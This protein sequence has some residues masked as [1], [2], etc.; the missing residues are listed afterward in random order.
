MPPEGRPRK[1][2]PVGSERMTET[3]TRAP[4]SRKEDWITL[5][6]RRVYDDAIQEAVPPEML[7]MLRGLDELDDGTPDDTPDHTPDDDDP[8]EGGTA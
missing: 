4:G 3:N 7:E 6:F 5:Q 2:K 1:T 8:D